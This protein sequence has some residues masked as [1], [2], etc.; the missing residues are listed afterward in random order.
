MRPFLCSI[1]VLVF[2]LLAWAPM[3][4]AQATHDST[5]SIAPTA[6]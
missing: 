1:A 5:I 2:V 4:H 6:S 3:A